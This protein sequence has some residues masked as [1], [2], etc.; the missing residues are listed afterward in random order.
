M[1]RVMSLSEIEREFDGEW[2]LLVE[3]ETDNSLRIV[4]GKLAH[5]SRYRDEVYRK[6]VALKPKRSAIIYTGSI[7]RGSEIIV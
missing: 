1:E 6:A 2:V 5:H 4:N 3:P 7:P